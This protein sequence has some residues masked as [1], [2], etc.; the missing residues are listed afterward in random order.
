[1]TSDLKS[2]T[3]EDIDGG[4]VLLHI[5]KSLN[6][7]I[8]DVM[9]INKKSTAPREV[10]LKL[11]ILPTESRREAAVEYSANEKLA[12]NPK[13]KTQILLARTDDGDVIASSAALNDSTGVQDLTIN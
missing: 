6:A 12:P 5:N 9:N 8:R 10:V 4:N 3:I 7:A 2:L 11:T 1:M 13:T